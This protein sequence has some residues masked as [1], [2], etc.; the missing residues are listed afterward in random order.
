MGSYLFGVFLAVR[1]RLLCSGT[2]VTEACVCV[3]HCNCAFS[4]QRKSLAY[5]ARV[6]V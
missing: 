6:V 1:T 2:L 4:I 3:L 5:V